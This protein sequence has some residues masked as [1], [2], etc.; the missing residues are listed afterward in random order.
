MLNQFPKAQEKA[1]AQAKEKIRGTLLHLLL[2]F[3]AFSCFFIILSLSSCKK[4]QPDTESQ[5]SVDNSICEGE[6]SGIFPQVNGIAVGD[7]GVQK[8]IYLP[9]PSNLCPEH[10][11]DSADIADGFPITMHLEYGADT[12]WDGVYDYGC[13]GSD[14][15]YRKGMIESVFDTSWGTAGVKV[16]MNLLNYSV[17]GVM[18]EGTISVIKFSPSSFTQTVTNGKISASGWTILWNS[19]RTIT[20]YTNPQDPNSD[21]ALIT[22]SANGTDRNGK[23][24]SVEI[25]SPLRKEMSCRWLVSGR[26]TLTPEGRKSRTVDFGD[27]TCDN[28][29]KLIIDDNEYE[30][31]LD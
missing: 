28:R 15:K 13:T 20:L 1:Q 7:S 11:I 30:F 6:F 19:T 18:Y 14:G 3:S 24:F 8:G 22:G 23:T 25:N 4:E 29:A 9:S 31:I 10:W 21:V 12:T 2:L 16:T 17:N 26:L 27:G 5:S